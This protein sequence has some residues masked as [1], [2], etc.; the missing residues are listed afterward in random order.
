M[1]YKAICVS[2][3]GKRIEVI[4]PNGMT[5]RQAKFETNKI[6]KTW[7]ISINLYKHNKKA[8]RF[9]GSWHKDTKVW[10]V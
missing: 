10:G 5:D 7:A 9:V 8:V 3:N 6:C 4:I 1:K 2:N